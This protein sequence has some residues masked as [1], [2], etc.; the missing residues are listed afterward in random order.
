MNRSALLLLALFVSAC[1]DSAP[2][3]EWRPSDHA[4][5]PEVGNAPTTT[6]TLTPEEARAQAGSALFRM[7]C[8]TCHGARGQGDGPAARGLGVPDLTT[9]EPQSRLADA[10]IA[11]VIRSGRGAM[12]PF[13]SRI[14]DAGIAALVG[15][16]RSFAPR[17]EPTPAQ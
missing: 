5:P 15:H 16:V 13:G 17:T 7:Q 6:R 10:D 8:A 12:P 14:D 1:G 4:Q 2:R 9:A 11:A 3:R